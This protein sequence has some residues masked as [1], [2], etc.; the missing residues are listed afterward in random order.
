MLD[1]TDSPPTLF[2]IIWVTVF[3]VVLGCLCYAIRRRNALLPREQGLTPLYTENCGAHLG[4]ANLSAPLVRLAIYHDFLVVASVKTFL[5]RLDDI[6]SVE[7]TRGLFSRGVRISHS[8]GNNPATI[9]VW[10]VDPDRIVDLV[11]SRPNVLVKA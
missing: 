5:I 7:I 9:T 2:W 6:D 8:T 3:A 1:M 11:R 10:S 4:W